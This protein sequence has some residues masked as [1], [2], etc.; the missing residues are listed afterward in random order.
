MLSQQPLIIWLLFNIQFLITNYAF[1]LLLRDY[2]F[3]NPPA[4]RSTMTTFYCLSFL[5]LAQSVRL[6]VPI[7]LTLQHRC[8]LRNVMPL[9]WLPDTPQTPSQG[10]TEHSE[11]QK[12]CQG[13]LYNHLLILPGTKRVLVGRF[14]LYDKPCQGISYHISACPEEMLIANSAVS[15]FFIHWAVDLCY[16]WYV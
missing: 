16:D 1:Q 8:Y 3:S 10:N 6:L 5:Y 12:V 14:Y 2:G 9:H 15:Y 11:E 7:P 4:L 13:Y